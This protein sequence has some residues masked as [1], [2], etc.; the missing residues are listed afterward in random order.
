MT[1]EKFLA[2]RWNNQLTLGMEIPVLI[3]AYNTI[4]YYPIALLL[5]ALVK[6]DLESKS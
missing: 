6:K 5:L 3:Y 1:K 4:L 2:A